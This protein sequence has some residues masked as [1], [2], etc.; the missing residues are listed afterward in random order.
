[1]GLWDFRDDITRCR[2]LNFAATSG[3]TDAL[4]VTLSRSVLTQF[5]F[6]PDIFQRYFLASCGVSLNLAG[7]KVPHGLILSY[8]LLWTTYANEKPFFRIRPI[9]VQFRMDFRAVNDWYMARDNVVERKRVMAILSHGF[10]GGG[11]LL[12]SGSQPHIDLTINR[13]QTRVEITQL[14]E[15]KSVR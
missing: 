15:I 8:T 9:Y 10:H 13:T 12:A 11:G 6:A 1:M 3:L 7:R 5:V 4:C 14:R 2:S